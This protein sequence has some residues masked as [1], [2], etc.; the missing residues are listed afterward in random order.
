MVI[1][2]LLLYIMM[3]VMIFSSYLI[4]L[5]TYETTHLEG[6]KQD[7][8]KHIHFVFL[9]APCH[10]H[11]WFLTMPFGFFGVLLNQPACAAFLLHV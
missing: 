9:Y 3:V 11:A 4:P 2:S 6:N 5:E 1:V 10:K 8:Y 7:K